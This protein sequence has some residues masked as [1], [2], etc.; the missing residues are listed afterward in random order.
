M[1]VFVIFTYHMKIC[2]HKL[3]IISAYYMQYKMYITMSIHRCIILFCD[4]CLP[5]NYDL[6]SN[7]YIPVY[8]AGS[9]LPGPMKDNT[10]LIKI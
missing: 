7:I 2:Y 1:L 5:V 3:I 4:F 8:V 6:Q 10:S 9:V